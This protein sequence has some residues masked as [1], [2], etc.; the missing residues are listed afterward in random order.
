MVNVV[1]ATC[2]LCLIRSDIL[3]KC[4]K[5]PFLLLGVVVY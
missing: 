3:K 1:C 4:K 2:E 5:I